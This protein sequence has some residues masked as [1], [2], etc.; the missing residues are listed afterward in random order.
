MLDNIKLTNLRLYVNASNLFTVT[1]YA[2]WDP[3]VNADY[4]ASN[5]NL[6]TDFYSAPQP[7]TFTFGVRLGF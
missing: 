4:N 2:G 1:D 7:K 3:E 5:I 6:G